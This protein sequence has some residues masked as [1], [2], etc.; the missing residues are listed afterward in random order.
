MSIKVSQRRAVFAELK[1]YCMH[2]GDHDSMEVTEWSTG[3]GY[4]QLSAVI[5]CADAAYGLGGHI[6]ADG[7][8]TCPSDVVKQ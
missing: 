4:P 5:E 3:V 2:S 7:G 8:C 6:I 1:D